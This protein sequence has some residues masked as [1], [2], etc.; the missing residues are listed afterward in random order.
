MA[1]ENLASST[2]NIGMSSLAM[3]FTRATELS[4]LLRFGGILARADCS[5]CEVVGL[6]LPSLAFEVCNEEGVSACI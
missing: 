5:L 6:L 3:Y 1:L 2:T 4:D